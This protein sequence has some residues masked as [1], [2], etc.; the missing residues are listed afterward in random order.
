MDH[1]NPM[2][3][4]EERLY[5]TLLD[6]AAATTEVTT[7]R[8]LQTLASLFAKHYAVLRKVSRDANPPSGMPKDR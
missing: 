4:A 8:L 7:K 2:N 5:K 6:E 3:A 1:A